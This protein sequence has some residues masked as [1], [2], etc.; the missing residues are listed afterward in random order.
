MTDIDKSIKEAWKLI[1]DTRRDPYPLSENELKQRLNFTE[2]FPF[3]QIRQLPQKYFYISGR[4]ISKF[5]VLILIIAL[6]LSSV[7]VYAVVKIIQTKENVKNTDISIPTDSDITSTIKVRF[8]PSNLPEGYEEIEKNLTNTNS[9]VHYSNG[10]SDIFFRQELQIS[11]GSVDNEHTEEYNVIINGVVGIYIEKHG[12]KSLI[13]SNNEKYLFYLDSNSQ[14][15]TQD[16]LIKIAESLKQE[17][18]KE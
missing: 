5:F 14:Y 2:I 12:E 9:F 16:D 17:T 10:I 7:T 13:F 4:A 15:I 18:E 3:Y 1:V 11:N 8:F 6:F